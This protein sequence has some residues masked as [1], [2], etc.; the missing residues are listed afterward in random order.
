MTEI[1]QIK[2][3]RTLASCGPIYEKLLGAIGTEEFGSTVRDSVMSVTAGARRIYLYETTGRIE[4]SLQYYYCEPGLVD[5]LPLYTKSYM[6]LD[7]IQDAYRATPECSDI[8]FQRIR[9]SDIASAGFRRQFFDD[10]G[11]IERISIVQRGTDAWRGLNV[12][13]HESDGYFSDDE[14]TSLINLA[15]LALPML[16]LNRNRTDKLRQLTVS[17]MEER[18]AARFPALTRRERQV[19]ARAAIGMTVEATALDL[20]IGKTSVLTYRQRAYGR[21]NVTSPFQLCSLVS[22]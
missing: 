19:C 11:I 6:T 12:V 2:Q 9:P 5:L 13:R 15:W 22:H 21:L 8:A 17:Q 10:A 14:L 3:W 4:S 1:Q 7:P 18:F 20:A 16:P